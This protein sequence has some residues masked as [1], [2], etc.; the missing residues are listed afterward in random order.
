MEIA[1]KFVLDAAFCAAS[2]RAF[3]KANQY[4]NWARALR[5]SVVAVP[6]DCD[7][8]IFVLMTTILVY[9]S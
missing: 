7:D 4:C 5:I 3:D 1:F 9:E 8:G 6:R 2:I